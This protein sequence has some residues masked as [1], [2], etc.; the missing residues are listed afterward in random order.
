MMKIWPIAVLLTALLLGELAVADETANDGGVQEQQAEALYVHYF[1]CAQ[2]YSGPPPK[3]GGPT[4]DFPPRSV[5]TFRVELGESFEVSF[6]WKFSGKITREDDSYRA[7]LDCIKFH[8]NDFAGE[9]VLDEIYAPETTDPKFGGKYLRFA[10]SHSKDVEPFLKRQAKID[11][12]ETADNRVAEPGNSIAND[13]RTRLVDGANSQAND[14]AA[15]T[16]YLHYFRPAIDRRADVHAGTDDYP[17]YLFPPRHLLTIKIR[18][19]RPVEVVHWCAGR[20][21]RES[22]GYVVE[23]DGMYH[24][25]GRV[26]LEE[27]FELEGD[28]VVVEGESGDS[29]I[30]PC[31]AVVSKSSDI[32]PFLKAAAENGR[33]K[34]RPATAAELEDH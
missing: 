34:P 4:P 26:E 30:L 33:V 29:L 21:S 14:D 25:S 1:L 8:Q 31:Y 5:A 2:P 27:V 28:K 12:G 24:F 32:E 20:V 9:V 15:E 3:G 16:L 17:A 22:D 13:S 10:L 19:G 6:T 18:T 23:L 7:V 11:A